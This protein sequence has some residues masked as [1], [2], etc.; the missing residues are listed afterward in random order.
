MKALPKKSLGQNFLVDDNILNLIVGLGEIRPSDTVLEVGPGTGN[1]TV[2]I[3]RK[4]P[5][6]FIVVEK[7]KNLSLILKKKF[8]DQIEVIND[9]ILN[10]NQSFLYNKKIIIFTSECLYYLTR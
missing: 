8:N 1:L 7:D 4:N 2:K 3:L 9:D 5:K 10:Y 6:K